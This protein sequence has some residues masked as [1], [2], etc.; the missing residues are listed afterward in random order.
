MS[1]RG[2][3]IFQTSEKKVYANIYNH[4]DNYPEGAA[5]LFNNMLLDNDPHNNRATAFLKANKR[6][7]LT[8]CLHGDIEFIYYLTG[9]ELKACEVIYEDDKLKQKPFFVGDVRDFINKYLPKMY[10]ISENDGW[11]ER[12]EKERFLKANHWKNGESLESLKNKLM[13]AL[14]GDGDFSG[15][16]DAC[17]FDKG[18]PNKAVDK[19]TEILEKMSHFCD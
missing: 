13:T 4:W 19:I 8:S 6:A 11:R 12:N 15:W 16:I 2:Q 7:E 9:E 14:N 18:N 5:V 10:E 17:T 3:Y 1:T